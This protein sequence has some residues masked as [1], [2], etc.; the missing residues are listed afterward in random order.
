MNYF[1]VLCQNFIQMVLFSIC[2]LG[3]QN[4]PNS[5]GNLKRLSEMDLSGCN[6]NGSVPNSMANLTQLIY[7]DMSSNYFTAPIPSFSMARNLTMIDLSYNR[8]TGQITFS[9]WKE[10]QSLVYFYLHDNSLDGS[11]PASLFSLPSLQT[12]YLGNNQFSGQLHEFSNFS[13]FLLEE[14]DLSRN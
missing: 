2:C 12:L 7:L 4:F 13:S 10:L 5:N 14:L 9:H 3:V 1:K 6:F 11:I 8:L